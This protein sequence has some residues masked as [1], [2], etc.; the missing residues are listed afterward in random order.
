MPPRSGATAGSSSALALVAGLPHVED[1]RCVYLPSFVSGRCRNHFK[2]TPRSKAHCNVDCACANFHILNSRADDLL[3]FSEAIDRRGQA[4]LLTVVLAR[5]HK[6]TRNYQAPQTFDLQ[7]YA[8]RKDELPRVIVF[9]H[10]V[11]SM[12]QEQ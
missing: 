2:N 1:T 9:H 3:Q 7:A 10:I 8:I 11:E 12:T 5:N 6:P 4:K